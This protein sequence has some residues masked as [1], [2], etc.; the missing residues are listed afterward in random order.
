MERKTKIIS[1]IL[2]SVISITIFGG[3][4]K[5]SAEEKT[6]SGSILDHKV[7]DEPITLTFFAQKPQG[8]NNDDNVF[9]RA[10]EHTNVKLKHILPENAGDFGQQLAIAV[11]SKDM[12]DVIY[13][14]GR[15]TFI[16]YGKQGA[17]I[18]LNDLIEKHAPNL[19]K[20]LDENEDVKKYIT[21]SDGNIY[22]VPNVLDGKTSSGW[23]IRQDWLDKLGLSVP[24]TVS[25]LHDVLAAFR[26]RDPNGNGKKDEVPL[27]GTGSQV[28]YAINELLGIFNAYFGFR[29]ED[30]KVYFGPM[31]ENFKTAMETLSAWY[32]EGL[33]DKEFFTRSNTREYFLGN[34]LGGCTHNW[35]GSTAGYNKT[36]AESVPGIKFLPMAPPAGADGVRRELNAR[37]KSLIEGWSIS[38]TNEHPEETIKYF[39]FWWTEE[40]RKMAN[41]GIEGVT[42]TEKDG[43]IEYTDYVMNN[44]EYVPVNALRT[45]GAQTNFGY[46]QDWNSEALYIN[47]IALD[48]M[49]MYINNGYMP[50]EIVMLTYN[51]D[52][53]KK[54]KNLSAQITTCL[55]ETV[56]KWILGNEDVSETYDRFIKDLKSL[57]V[58]EYISIEQAAYERYLK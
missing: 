9:T 12:A 14:A 13:L 45:V 25:E 8:F 49:N 26:D 5:Q 10:F 16:S 47:D 43:K 35:F 31:E 19:K 51:E 7:S 17:F 55:E 23:F 2:I 41:Y 37:S 22:Y 39:D 57:G 54:V 32:A 4:G 42:Y 1:L 6:A 15:D 30:G 38:A 56:Q 44:S 36:Y 18:P 29:Y 28:K 3:C 58:D 48:G 53:E 24:N 33:I 50:D 52:E 27:F 46:P 34:D 11:S 40:G 21:A 20:Y